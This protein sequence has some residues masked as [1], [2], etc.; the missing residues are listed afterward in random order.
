MADSESITRP[1][2]LPTAHLRHDLT[3]QVFTSRTVLGY[4]GSR[5]NAISVWWCRCICGKEQAV[6]GSKLRRGL[7]KSCGCLRP[8]IGGYVGARATTERQSYSSAKTRCGNSNARNFVDYG[9][10]GI[11]FRFTSFEQ[12]L[13]ELGLKPSAKHSLDRIDVNGHYEPGNVRWATPEIQARNVRNPKWIT[14]RGETKNQA[15]WEE[16]YPHIKWRL[17]RGWCVVCAFEL[18]K[19]RSCRHKQQ[20]AIACL[21][22]LEAETK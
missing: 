16:T 11:E 18:A 21:A 15:E 3:N 5:Y 2:F 10:R 22:A 8:R 4:I 13:A 6:E 12:F 19:G 14:Y 1:P 20:R 9:G 17:H 7:S